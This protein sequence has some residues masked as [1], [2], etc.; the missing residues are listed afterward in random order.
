MSFGGSVKL[1]G[2]SEYKKALQEITQN[3]KVVS[4]EMKA[5]SS[6]FA[7]GDRTQKEVNKE[8]KEYSKALE[9]QKKTLAGLK[10]YLKARESDYAKMGKEHEKLVKSY[11]NESK[12][13]QDIKKDLVRAL[14]SLR[15][16]KRLLTICRM[17]SQRVLRP[18]MKRVRALIKCA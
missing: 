2:A 13:L 5:T 3:L 4:A 6:S 10:D 18:M 8:A 15:H 1:T 14:K 9:E 12:K 11:E 16:S 7:V 17:L